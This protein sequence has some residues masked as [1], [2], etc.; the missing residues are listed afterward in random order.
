MP[1]LTGRREASGAHTPVPPDRCQRASLN[2]RKASRLTAP[3]NSAVPPG[4]AFPRDGAQ[5]GFH[6]GNADGWVDIFVVN[7]DGSSRRAPNYTQT[8]RTDE[9]AYSWQKVTQ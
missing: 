7:S 6:S 5:V 9:F 2:T 4:G 8:R 3:D 1:L